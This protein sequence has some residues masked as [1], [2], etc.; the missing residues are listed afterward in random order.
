[1][2][3]TEVESPWGWAVPQRSA[4]ATI[5]GVG[6][7]AL[8]L[9]RPAAGPAVPPPP[10]AVSVELNSAPPAVLLALP[11]LGPSRVDRIV[12]AREEAPFESLADLERRVKGIGPATI[13]GIEPWARISEATGTMP[14]DR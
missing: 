14:P 7:I 9:G 11:G 5:V 2:T 13:R 10:G 4:L 6:A 3:R 12:S 8:L 1:M